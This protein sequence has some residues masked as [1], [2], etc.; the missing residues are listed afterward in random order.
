MENMEVVYMM[1]SACHHA[2][3]CV[4]AALLRTGEVSVR[5]SKDRAKAPQVYS[6]EEWDAFVQ[7]VKAGDFD[8]AA[9]PLPPAEQE[10]R[11]LAR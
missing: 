7:G 8:R 1:S 4:E 6:A 5:D 9:M 11:S 3:N 2:G 10:T